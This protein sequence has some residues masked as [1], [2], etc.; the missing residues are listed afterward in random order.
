[1]NNCLICLQPNHYLTS[2]LPDCDKCNIYYHIECFEN[3]R[4]LG[5]NCPLCRQSSNITN[6]HEYIFDYFKYLQFIFRFIES[7]VFRLYTIYPNIVTFVL[8]QLFTIPIM[9]LITTP[10]I[11]FLLLMFSLRKINRVLFRLNEYFIF[12]NPIRLI[13]LL[14]DIHLY[15]R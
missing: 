14:E 11:F 13:H 7:T 6:I 12:N 4:K 10:Y 2:T 8:L 15:Y 9:F 3:I 5:L 1:M